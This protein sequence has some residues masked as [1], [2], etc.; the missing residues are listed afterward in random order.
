MPYCD[1]STVRICNVSRWAASA[2]STPGGQ[3]AL[4]CDLLLFDVMVKISLALLAF[5]MQVVKV[6]QTH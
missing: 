4:Y 3:V 2:L 1:P 6:K 5:G